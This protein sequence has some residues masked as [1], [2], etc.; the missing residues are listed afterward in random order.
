MWVV[1]GIMYTFIQPGI[2]Q[3]HAI[4]DYATQQ[5][6]WNEAKAIMEDNI[7]P[8]HMACVPQFR[9]PIPDAP[10]TKKEKIKIQG[11]LT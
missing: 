6:C 10:S 2:M 4:K 7:S 9:P 5:Q 11:T 8:D 1:V 3:L